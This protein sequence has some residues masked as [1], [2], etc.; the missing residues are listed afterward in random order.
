MGMKLVNR[1]VR[2]ITPS[3]VQANRQQWKPFEKRVTQVLT[4]ENG[5]V[6]FG[7]T[8]HMDGSV[9]DEG[10]AFK[11]GYLVFVDGTEGADAE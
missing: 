4:D 10:L 6:D 2:N 9:T 1:M 8:P 11:R 3:Y 7:Y 5:A